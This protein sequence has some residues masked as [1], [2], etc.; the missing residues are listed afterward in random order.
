MLQWASIFLDHLGPKQSEVNIFI[1]AYPWWKQR[2]PERQGKGHNPMG[3]I[4]SLEFWGLFLTACATKLNSS[5]LDLNILTHLQVPQ[6][7]NVGTFE[8]HLVHQT[9]VGQLQVLDKLQTVS[10][11]QCVPA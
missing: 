1:L 4:C 7:H 6:S 5:A 8:L 10:Q 3:N 9:A 2:K 11:S